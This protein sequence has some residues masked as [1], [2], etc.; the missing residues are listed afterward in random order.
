MDA[1]KYGLSNCSSAHDKKGEKNIQCRFSRVDFFPIKKNF[2]NTFLRLHLIRKAKSGRDT[3]H[4]SFFPYLL[5]TY[6]R[7]LKVCCVRALHVLS[8]H[9]HGFYLARYTTTTRSQQWEY[10]LVIAFFNVK[11]KQEKKPYT[12][13]AW[14]KGQGGVK[15]TQG[16]FIFSFPFSLSFLLHFYVR[17]S[18]S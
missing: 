16:H 12:V 13:A 7:I 15:R 6:L 5:Y 8:N 1:T 9:G 4:M 11:R 10:L 3:W 17:T 14:K 2:F 18:S